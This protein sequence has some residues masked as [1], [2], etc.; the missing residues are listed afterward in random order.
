MTTLF[1]ALYTLSFATVDRVKALREDERGASAV[2]YALLVG[3][4]ALVVV[5][6]IT[7]FGQKLT[8]LFNGITLT[9]SA[10]AAPTS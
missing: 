5:A 10:P 7:L 1:Q 3:A 4:L 8:T 6:A 2:E 9:P